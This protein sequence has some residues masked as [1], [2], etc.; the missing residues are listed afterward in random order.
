MMA[1]PLL[2]VHP[3]CAPRPVSAMSTPACAEPWNLPAVPKGGPA[4]PSLSFTTSRWD[5][6]S[7]HSRSGPGADL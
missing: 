5:T 4:D 3:H 6:P 2:P 7:F 1:G